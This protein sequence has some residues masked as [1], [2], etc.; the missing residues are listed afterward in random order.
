MSAREI[1]LVSICLPT[2]NGERYLEEALRSAFAQTY[3]RLEIVVSDD[4]ST[5]ATLAIIER[6]RHASPVPMTVHHHEPAGI[7]ANW[8]H[9]VQHASGQYIKFLFQDDLLAPECIQRMMDL[10][11][12]D[13]R[14]GLVHC[15]RRILHDPNDPGHARWME[16]YGTLHRSWGE[17]VVREGIVDGKRFLRDS[18]FMD[19]PFN[20]IGEPTAVLLKKECF[21]R[22]AFDTRLRQSLDYIFWYSVMRTYSIGFVDAE[23]AVFRLHR[24]QATQKNAEGGEIIDQ[25]LRKRLY[26]GLYGR[27]LHP[28]IRRDLVREFTWHGRLLT[29]LRSAIQRLAGQPRSGHA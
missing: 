22:M 2:Y 10:A 19:Q 24:E 18:R 3:P 1:P 6:L 11:L 14:V 28:D 15:R 26:L 29:R 21:E 8:N 9:C 20:K 12:M 23:L 25:K 16:R 4:R 13:A 17:I 5:D 7:G 27:F